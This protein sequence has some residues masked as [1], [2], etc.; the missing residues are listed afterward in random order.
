MCLCNCIKTV[1][2]KWHCAKQRE[3]FKR[4]VTLVNYVFWGSEEQMHHCVCVH[5][6]G[7]HFSLEKHQRF[8]WMNCCHWRSRQ[9]KLYVLN[10]LFLLHLLHFHSNESLEKLFGR[11]TDPWDTQQTNIHIKRVYNTGPNTFT[12]QKCTGKNM[13][14]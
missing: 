9:Q 1:K 3:P 4:R 5:R 11:S 7:N 14:Q 8:S 10:W 2:Q 12:Q 13:L 6:N